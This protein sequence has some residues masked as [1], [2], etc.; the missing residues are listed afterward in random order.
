MTEIRYTYLSGTL[1]PYDIKFISEIF[2]SERAYLGFAR[3][4]PAWGQGTLIKVEKVG[5]GS[6]PVDYVEYFGGEGK[7]VD[8]MC[9]TL[10][11]SGGSN[12]IFIARIPPEK[13]NSTNLNDFEFIPENEIG[14]IYV[15]WF[16]DSWFFV[17]GLRPQY[18]FD[19]DYE[20]FIFPASKDINLRFHI[21]RI[22]KDRFPKF[23]ERCKLAYSTSSEKPTTILAE[24]GDLLR[25][26]NTLGEEVI[27]H[28]N[29]SF[30]MPDDLKDLTF[31]II[32]EN[33]G[34]IY[35]NL[36][37]VETVIT[38]TEKFMVFEYENIQGNFT[39]LKVTTNIESLSNL[40]IYPESTPYLFYA[41]PIA[42][43]NPPPLR[44]AYIRDGQIEKSIFDVRGIIKIKKEEVWYAKRITDENERNYLV[45]EGWEL[46]SIVVDE[47]T[48]TLAYYA[49]TQDRDKAINAN[50]DSIYIEKEVPNDIP[51]QDIYRQLFI[52]FAPKDKD[53][54]DCME[55][56]YTWE[57]LFN[58]NK[59]RYDI[60]VL[61]YLANKIPVYRKYINGTEKFVLI[62]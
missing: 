40:A 25:T 34:I 2:R 52:C 36:K 20:Y 24:A 47:E 28:L 26:L 44:S 23:T 19:L 60:G 5:S 49:K 62:L 18:Y 41:K 4:E 58:K 55:N 10:G 46:V 48:N 30:D 38:D 21:E 35:P 59:W 11:Y 39:R 37:Y 57:E 61:I 42:D 7:Y 51:T 6:F 54:F 1:I 56:F 29:P 16:N 31:W 17:E 15:K 9:R 3:H 22:K 50:F 14:Q 12:R 33:G 27:T 45:G 53:G 32:D 13:A 8:D 43:D